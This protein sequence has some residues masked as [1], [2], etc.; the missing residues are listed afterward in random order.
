MRASRCG[1][2]RRSGPQQRHRRHG[3]GLPF[4][5][6]EGYGPGTYTL[7]RRRANSICIN[8]RGSRIEP[9]AGE[10]HRGAAA[11]DRGST[12]RKVTGMIIGSRPQEIKWVV[13]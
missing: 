3:L 12:T 4:L 11:A 2:V 10:Q 8:L 1:F 13:S 7:S 9:Y 6:P 5:G